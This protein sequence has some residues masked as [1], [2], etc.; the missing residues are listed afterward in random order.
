MRFHRVIVV[1]RQLT[2]A[3]KSVSGFVVPS[4]FEMTEEQNPMWCVSNC[5]FLLERG[6]ERE[7]ARTQKSSG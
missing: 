2:L 5:T 7:K 1:W 6:H 4:A 3:R